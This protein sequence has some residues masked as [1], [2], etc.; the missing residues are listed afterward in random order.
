MNLHRSPFAGRNFEYFSED[1][2]LTGE[3]A[4]EQMLGADEFG[5]YSF[6][7][8]FAL[9]EQ[10]NER[11]GQLCTWSNEQAIREIYL[12]PFE[13]IVKGRWR[14]PGHDGVLQLHRQ[15]LRQRP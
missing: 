7:K 2:L 11:N 15:H 10:E 13:I 4:A 8:H 14:R 12:K 3:L 6:T 1:P 5:V 9:N